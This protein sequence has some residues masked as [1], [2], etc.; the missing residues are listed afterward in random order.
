MIRLLIF[1]SIIGSCSTPIN[2]IENYYTYLYSE[3]NGLNV[4]VYDNGLFY[5]LQYEPKSLCA[6]KEVTGEM[7]MLSAYKSVLPQFSDMVYFNVNIDVD[8]LDLKMN[9]DSLDWVIDDFRF[10]TESMFCLITSNSDTLPCLIGHSIIS[11]DS[12]SLKIKSELSFERKQQ[13][14]EEINENV[15]ILHLVNH[16]VV[17]GH[18]FAKSNFTSIPQLNL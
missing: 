11:G 1:M 7:Q 16:Q 18:L 9:H 5:S 8:T 15:K 4:N 10:R 13:W 14:K 3:R 6:L 17:F 2:R 12:Q